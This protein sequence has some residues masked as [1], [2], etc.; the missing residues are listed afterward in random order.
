M[1]ELLAKNNRR[2][3]KALGIIFCI[4]ADPH[5]KHSIL[6]GTAHYLLETMTILEPG[7]LF[8]G[9]GKRKFSLDAFSTGKVRAFSS[10]PPTLCPK[11]HSY[12]YTSKAGIA[13]DPDE[14][15]DDDG[16]DKAR[17]SNQRSD[18]KVAG[19][20]L[21][22]HCKH[23]FNAADAITPPGWEELLKSN[24]IDFKKGRFDILVATKGFGM[25]IDKSSVRFVVHT[26]L[27]SGLESWYQEVGRAGRDNERA[28]IVLLCE[29]PHPDCSRKLFEL[30]VPRPDC[31]YGAGCSFGKPNLCD[32]GKQHMFI[33]G[34]YPGAEADAMS[35][36]GVLD[37][38]IASW[39]ARPEDSI[40]VYASH[41][42]ISRKEIALY[43]LMVLGLIADYVITY[44]RTPRFDVLFV[45]A[46]LTDKA[47]L[48]RLEGNFSVRL[49]DYF[50]NF[51]GSRQE[52]MS[53][54]MARCRE[55]YR[56]LEFFA[57]KLDKFEAY[58]Q[59]PALFHSAY[60]HL[61]LLL[62]HTYRNVVKMRY[63]MLYN[64]LDVVATDKCRRLNFLQRLGDES[65]NNIDVSYRCGMCDIC[66]PD[67]VFP[68]QR[69]APVIPSPTE[70]DRRLEKALAEDIFDLEMIRAI[71]GDFRDYPTAKYRQA[72]SILEGNPNNMVALYLSRE[73]PP[74]AELIGNAKRLLLAANQ[75]RL[76]LAD[77]AALYH[78]SPKNMESELLLLPNDPGSACDSIEGWRFL[79]A[80][81]AKPQHRQSGEVRMMGECLDFFLFVESAAADEGH[82][83]KDKARRLAEAFRA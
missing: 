17:V 82:L 80:E 21:C 9:R 83:L 36:L 33:S 35:A 28:H 1:R 47:S 38:L 13:A 2:G 67:L 52:T 72:W 18:G 70:K 46:E 37:K 79:A 78:T 20:K 53:Q 10:K 6:D 51:S 68:E 41:A 5:G 31:N 22:S 76:P 11:C 45:G 23:E 71:V 39:M 58:G 73:F 77:I 26:S 40:G 12:A 15:S 62:D 48:S 7:A 74:S 16:A 57:Q 24:Q 81:A 27:S 34:S 55:E 43:R 19:R 3:E 8:A 66:A 14:L 25:G 64:L 61:L 32:Y 30:T 75:R 54:R 60:E 50:A 49:A 56:P 65:F 59:A 63:F 29:P 44:G 42:H 69:V 4:Y